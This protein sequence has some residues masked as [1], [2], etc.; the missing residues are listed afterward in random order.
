[1]TYWKGTAVADVNSDGSLAQSLMFEIA[2]SGY[3]GSVVTA[4]SLTYVESYIVG[5]IAVLDYEAAP[6]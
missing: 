5:L 2:L 1:V 4:S 3:V 6:P